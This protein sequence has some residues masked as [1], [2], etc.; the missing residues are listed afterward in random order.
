[1][2]MIQ[3]V[4]MR[5]IITC[6]CGKAVVTSYLFWKP[7][8]KVSSHSS[9]S[10]KICSNLNFGWKVLMFSVIFTMSSS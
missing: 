3:T 9:A 5:E 10:N 7:S 4:L 1:M 2:I 8:K 6:F